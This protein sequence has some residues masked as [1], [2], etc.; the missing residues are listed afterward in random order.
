[1]Q[2]RAVAIL[3]ACAE[4]RIG[5]DFIARTRLATEGEDHLI[6]GGEQDVLETAERA[7]ITFGVLEKPWVELIGDKR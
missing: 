3:L 2:E 4:A 1:M 5:G 6:I 7:R